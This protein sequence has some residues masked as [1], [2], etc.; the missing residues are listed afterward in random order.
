MP[1]FGAAAQPIELRLPRKKTARPAV[2]VKH[3]CRIPFCLAAIGDTD[4]NGRADLYVEH[5]F[6]SLYAGSFAAPY[7]A[8]QVDDLDTIKAF[9]QRWSHFVTQPAK[10]DLPMQRMIHHEDAE[11]V[12]G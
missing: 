4:R 6:I 2:L 9:A 5:S 7:I 3:V 11:T 10:V 12:F 8:A 1:E